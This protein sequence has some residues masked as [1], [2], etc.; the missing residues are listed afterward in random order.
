[1]DDF[2]EPDEPLKHPYH[3]VNDGTQLLELGLGI[4][5]CEKCKTQFVPTCSADEQTC[6]LTWVTPTK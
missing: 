3:C 4:L 6:F 5:F 2:Q 1:M